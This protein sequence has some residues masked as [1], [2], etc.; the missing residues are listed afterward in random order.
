[1][2]SASRCL[3]KRYHFCLRK[4]SL[5]YG[6]YGI[7][8]IRGI[9]LSAEWSSQTRVTLEYVS[10]GLFTPARV[11]YLT[12][13][14]NA[15]LARAFQHA[16]DTD[17]QREA[18]L[19]QAR[20]ELAN[21]AAAI[22]QGIITPTTKTMLEDAER[23]VAHLEQAIR[24]SR[25]LLPP[26]VSVRAVVERCLRDLRVTFGTNVD[27]ARHILSLA[28]EKIVLRPEGQSLSPISAGISLGYLDWSRL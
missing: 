3:L 10:G 22:R 18:A 26:A 12:S 15:A 1:M 5:G 4:G 14:V 25:R 11:D 6:L 27:A 23:R 19:C 16:H 8:Q 9:S 28:L 17:A 20:Q 7:P 13:A 21:V 24:G 2:E